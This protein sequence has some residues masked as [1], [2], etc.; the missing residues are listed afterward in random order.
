MKANMKYS[1]ALVVVLLVFAFALP[2]SSS[3]R[4]SFGDNCRDQ[5]QVRGQGQ[6]GGQDGY[7]EGQS[8]YEVVR[9]GGY[10]GGQGG[11]IGGRQGG[12]VGGGQGVGSGGQGGS[13]GRGFVEPKCGEL[14]CCYSKYGHCL[15]C[16]DP[17][18]IPP[19]GMNQVNPN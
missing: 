9:G 3:A 16:C 11:C 13:G 10:S 14:G 18:W 4:S 1:L 17:W 7:G 2:L 15:R 6:A 19:G 8:G 5:N 12:Y